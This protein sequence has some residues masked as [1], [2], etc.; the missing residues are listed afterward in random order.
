[1]M[2]LMIGLAVGLSAYGY[3]QYFHSLPQT[4]ELYARNPDAALRDAGVWYPPGSAAREQFE[5]R[6]MST[7]PIATFALTNSLAGLLAPWLVVA[8]GIAIVGAHNGQ[9][10]RWR[11][12]AA[13]LASA[14]VIAG[15][16]ML[17]KS[18]SAY[19]AVMAGVAIL[20]LFGGARGSLI[21]YRRRVLIGVAGVVC[22]LIALG[23][24]VG[25]LDAGV[26]NQA[27][28]SLGYRMEYWE[29]TL[30]MIRDYPVTG[31]GPGNFQFAYTQYKLP[32]A[33]EEIQDPHNFLLEV[34]ATAGTPARLP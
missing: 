23:M 7:E 16:L 32:R 12:T 33:S 26:L 6:L 9:R 29:A 11:W 15:C 30:A 14:I 34:W 18:R 19:L 2:V 25:G 10:N 22:L 8:V 31:S 20:L 21:P 24:L 1:M 13:A 17:T 4:R 5:Q 27:T 3:Y 28:K